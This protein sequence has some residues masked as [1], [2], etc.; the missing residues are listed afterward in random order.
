MRAFFAIALPEPQRRA[1]GELRD[2]LRTE[3]IRAAWVRDENFHVTLRFLGDC[4][5]ARLEAMATQVRGAL[6]EQRVFALHLA[7]TGAFPNPRKAAVLWAGLTDASH[8]ELVAV[9]AA[10]EAAARSAGLAAEPKA[11]HGHVTLGRIRQPSKDDRLARVLAD[12]ADFDGGEFAVTTISLLRSELTSG[13]AVYSS[14]DE[15]PLLVP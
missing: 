7:G 2:A 8:A 15:I 10:T 6:A 12:H 13:G 11:F 1:L 3:G 14:L 9:Q 4:D 5:T